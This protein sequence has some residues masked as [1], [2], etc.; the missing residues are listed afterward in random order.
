MPRYAFLKT[1]F[2]FV[3]VYTKNSCWLPQRVRQPTAISRSGKFLNPDLPG[4]PNLQIILQ[5]RH[6]ASTSYDEAT[7]E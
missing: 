7:S 2:L 3:G 5:E 4:M 1:R 6:L